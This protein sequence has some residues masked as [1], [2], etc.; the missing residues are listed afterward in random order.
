VCGG[1]SREEKR[2]DIEPWRA[3][4]SL[5][6]IRDNAKMSESTSIGAL[7]FAKNNP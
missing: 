3:K 2:V 5:K 4:M 6:A 7:A 1:F